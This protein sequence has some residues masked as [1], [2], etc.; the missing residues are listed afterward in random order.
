MNTEIN[1]EL[2]D[3]FQWILDEDVVLETTE[4]PDLDSATAVFDLAQ[5]DEEVVPLVEETRSFV[6]KPQETQSLAPMYA[7]P[8]PYVGTGAFPPVPDPPVNSAPRPV[9]IVWGFV[10]MA[11]G[12]LAM[13]LAAGAAVDLGLVLVWLPAICGTALILAAILAATRKGRTSSNC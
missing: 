11:I 12:V 2:T 1:T 8:E 13:S 10:I 9:T 4:T 7:V 5:N 6:S 3:T